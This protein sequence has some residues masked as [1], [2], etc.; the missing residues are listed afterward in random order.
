MAAKNL[1]L[2]SEAPMKPT[3]LPKRPTIGDFTRAQIETHEC[4]EEARGEIR[5]VEGRLNEVVGRMDTLAERQDG[6]GTRIDSLADSLGGDIAAIARRVGADKPGEMKVKRGNP[7][8]WISAGGA[9]ATI[10]GFL[11]RISPAWPEIVR[12]FHAVLAAGSAVLAAA[13]AR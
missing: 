5:K 9:I 12:A 11:A 7:F 4:V 13:G 8:A 2:V 6:L 3:P 1:R 10:L